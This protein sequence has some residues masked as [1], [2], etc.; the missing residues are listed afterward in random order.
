MPEAQNKTGPK[1]S[2]MVPKPD[3]SSKVPDQLKPRICQRLAHYQ[4]TSEIIAWLKQEHGISL[5]EKAV[6]HYRDHKKWQDAFQRFRAQYLA[7]L[8]EVAGHSIRWRLERLQKRLRHL[9]LDYSRAGGSVFASQE[10]FAEYREILD[11]MRREIG[12]RIQIS[13]ELNTGDDRVV[14]VPQDIADA[15]GMSTDPEDYR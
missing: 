5:T 4:A 15:L 3:R 2:D 11:Q 10:G 1:Q 9:E 7:D 14:V 13:G 8:Q 6:Y 12:D